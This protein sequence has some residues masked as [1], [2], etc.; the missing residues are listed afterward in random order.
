MPPYVGTPNS[1]PIAEGNSVQGTSA[2]ASKS[3]R[4][5]QRTPSLTLPENEQNGMPS[6]QL[7]RSSPDSFTAGANKTNLGFG[8][9]QNEPTHR[10]SRLGKFNPT[11]M[12][13]AE[14]ENWLRASL[15]A[16]PLEKKSEK[17]D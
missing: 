6:G 2:E 12:T 1:I 13:R 7:L 15:S 14:I 17:W 9:Y 10:K 4:D 8:A 16:S 11:D 3:S 5:C